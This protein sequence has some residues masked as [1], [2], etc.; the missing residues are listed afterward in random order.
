MK[1]L[2][3]LILFL[4]ALSHFAAKAQFGYVKKEDVDKIKDSRLVVILFNDS[5]YNASVLK[6]VERYWKFTGSYLVAYDTSAILKEYNKKNDYT[7]LVF[8][9]GKASLKIKIR[10]CLSEEDLNGL[11][12]TRK[13]KK[14]IL[15]DNALAYSF[16][17]NRIDTNEWYPEI[18]RSLQLMNNYLDITT[19]AA[20]DKEISMGALTS[21][22][23]TNKSLMSGKTLYVLKEQ[24]GL[25]GKEDGAQIW[26]DSYEEIDE[27]EDLYKL[28][29]NQ[30]DDAI[31][32]FSSKD[33][34]FCNKLFI[35][36]N[37]NELM[38]FTSTSS[39]DDCKC[40]AKDIK[41]LRTL[42]D[43]Q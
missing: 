7:Y 10:A 37:G 8:S 27:I 1:K 3:T 2:S 34:K 42:R 29:L 19:T 14:K 31:Y 26:G 21:N 40:T 20:S 22:Y 11:V 38:Y 39:T 9:K 4:F 16:C 12:L 32:F 25:K 15:P 35:I 30:A 17:S 33:D 28:I 6:A 36:A 23:P 5:A 13:F 43:K 24:V 18:V 41:N